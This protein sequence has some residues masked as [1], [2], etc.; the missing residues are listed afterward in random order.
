MLS[1]LVSFQLIDSVGK[2]FRNIATIAMTTDN[3]RKEGVY[4]YMGYHFVK[5]VVNPIKDKKLMPHLQYTDYD[6]GVRVF[7]NGLRNEV[8]KDLI[9]AINLDKVLKNRDGSSLMCERY[10]LKKTV[11]LKC[12]MPDGDF[13]VTGIKFLNKITESKSYQVDYLA[14]NNI[15]KSYSFTS[16]NI[17]NTEKIDSLLKIP[18]EKF[19]YFDT[20]SNKIIDSRYFTVTIK[21]DPEDTPKF[22]ITG[23]IKNIGEHYILK[24]DATDARNYFAISKNVIDEDGSF[25]SPSIKDAVRQIMQKPNNITD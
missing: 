8:T 12:L 4:R 24:W 21:G 25:V 19:D 1:L 22:S 23:H 18:Y 3:E 2:L 13:H 16:K 20:I 15:I 11:Q 17:V 9:V 14:N 7:L 6:Y 10:A 5:E